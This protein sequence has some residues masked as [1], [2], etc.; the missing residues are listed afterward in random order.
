VSF[1]LRP[2]TW[3]DLP[4][5]VET[6]RAVDLHDWGAEIGEENDIRDD[7]DLPLFD[8]E[9]DT[10]VAV[11]EQGRIVA[12]A[13]IVRE[14]E[15]PEVFTVGFVH[16]EWRSR[17]IGSA[18]I[19]SVE[20][21]AGEI[22]AGRKG[23]IRALASPSD[24][25]FFELRGWRFA[26]SMETMTAS[27]EDEPPEITS[28]GALIHPSGPDDAEAV[29]AVLMA[30]FSRHYG[31]VEQSFEEWR[32]HYLESPRSDTSLWFVAKVNDALVA[33]T[34]GVV[35]L[36]MGWVAEVGVLEDWRRRGIGAA[37]TVRLMH[38]FRTRGQTKVGLNVDPQNETGAIRLYERLGFTRD[39]RIDF[40]ELTL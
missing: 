27:L 34:I 31:F 16:P 40:Y 20:A 23:L 33:V 9:R 2:A 1:T 13:I 39:K 10:V 36:G 22:V 3:D 5:I 17:G 7:W 19:E 6:M 12:Y 35:R 37:L 18:L 24:R 8:M 21:R 4:A 29:H 14:S 38:E 26:R 11:G 15:G 25:T 30:S 32:S 28:E